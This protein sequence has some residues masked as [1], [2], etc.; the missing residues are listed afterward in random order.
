MDL[1]TAIAVLLGVLVRAVYLSAIQYKKGD[2]IIITS[3]ILIS[4]LIAGEVAE[5]G[6][7]F[8]LAVPL[9]AVGVLAFGYKDRILMPVG[10]SVA[11]FYSLLPTNTPRRKPGDVGSSTA[12][13]G[14][15]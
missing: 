7:T 10:E 3:S 8:W 11:L 12:T 13:C 4:I 14:S 15:C 1:I 5:E 9:A 6:N 2:G